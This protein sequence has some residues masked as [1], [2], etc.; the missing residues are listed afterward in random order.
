MKDY[1]KGVSFEGSFVRDHCIPCLV[2]KSP[3]HSYSHPGNRAAKIGELLHMDICG[4]FP[5][6]APHGE[7]YFLSILDDKSNWG[8]A[9]GLKLKSDAFLKY[10][11]MEAF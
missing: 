11:A 10:L 4:P 1:V 6:Q 8:L 5:V 3:Q 9:Y 7:K 2:G